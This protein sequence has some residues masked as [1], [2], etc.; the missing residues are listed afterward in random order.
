MKKKISQIIKIIGI[1]LTEIIINIEIDNVTI[2]SIEW[3]QSNDKIYLHIFQ[4]DN[5]DIEMDFDD[6]SE[7]NKFIV[8]KTLS[9]IIYN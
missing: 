9:E 6:L 8:L 7:G 3:V 5:V 2:N 1:G 4:D